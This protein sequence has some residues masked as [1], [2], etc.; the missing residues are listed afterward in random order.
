MNKKS[1]IFIFTYCIPSF[2]SL[3]YLIA[4]FVCYKKG[5]ALDL[6]NKTEGFQDLCNSMVNFLT[7]ILGIYGVIIPIVIGKMDEEY[8]KRFWSL[9]NKN[10]FEKDIKKIILLGL[11]SILLCAVL[12]LNDVLPIIINN[13]FI[14]IVIWTFLYF[15]VSS[16][17]F[18]SI[19]LKLIIGNS[20]T[21][22]QKHKLTKEQEE[23]KSKIEDL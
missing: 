4:L 2:F 10:Q 9:I 11:F 22:R 13:I 7:I 12:M 5:I 23:T 3:L 17:R 21:P 15:I 19:F 1:Y 16:Y 18:I 14:T 8:S 20:R 6:Y